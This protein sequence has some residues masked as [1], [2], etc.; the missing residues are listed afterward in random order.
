MRIAS[1]RPVMWGSGATPARKPAMRGW[2][3]LQMLPVAAAACIMLTVLTPAGGRRQ[4]SAVYLACSVILFGMSALYHRLYWEPRAEKLLRRTDHMNIFLLIAGTCTPLAAG[5]MR[6]PQSTRFIIITWAG[7]ATGILLMLLW[8]AAPRWLSTM[9]Y[10]LL[11]STVIWFLPSWWRTSPP[12]V[13]LTLV[14]GLVYLCGAVIYASRWPNPSDR[15]FGFHEIF[16]AC[17]VLAWAATCVG[18]YVAILG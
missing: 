7:A 9:V 12:A 2:L 10:V 6:P 15:Y 3:H 17:T 5:L 16:H 18:V 14:G 11:G 13:I 8:P 1:T 4:A